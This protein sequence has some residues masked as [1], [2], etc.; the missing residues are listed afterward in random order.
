MH[1]PKHQKLGVTLKREVVGEQSR[2]EN[3][4]SVVT[5]AGGASQ[6]KD[7]KSIKG[8]ICSQ[9]R[10]NRTVFTHHPKDPNCEVCKKTKTTRARYRTKPKKRVD[11][12]APSTKFGDLTTADHKKERGK[13][14]EM[15]TQKRS[16]RAR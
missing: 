1:L 6:A 8:I 12:I 13:R 4:P 5:D 10:E 3:L 16:N 2:D 11:G 7:T 9:P 14:V 15:R